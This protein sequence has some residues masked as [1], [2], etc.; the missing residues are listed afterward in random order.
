M[1]LDP[2]SFVEKPLNKDGFVPESSR[3][4]NRFK[5]RNP[6]PAPSFAAVEGCR[7]ILPLISVQC[8]ERLP[9]SFDAP[10]VINL[11]QPVPDDVLRVQPQVVH[12]PCCELAF[13]A[14]EELVNSPG[15]LATGAQRLPEKGGQ[16][17]DY[18]GGGAEL[19]QDLDRFEFARHAYMVTREGVRNRLVRRPKKG[20]GGKQGRKPVLSYRSCAAT[21]DCLG[22]LQPGQRREAES[23]EREAELT[24]VETGTQRRAI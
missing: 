21:S 15:I 8:L 11:E 10:D 19:Y 5:Q 7:P 2:G 18:L 3:M 14:L 22:V 24:A 13:N 16:P 4:P 6:A 23:G 17:R 12:T 20:Q 9:H 1:K